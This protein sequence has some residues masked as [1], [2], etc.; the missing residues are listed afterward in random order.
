MNFNLNVALAIFF[1]FIMQSAFAGAP[2]LMT[3]QSKIVLPTGAALES[4]SVNF[5]F[6]ILDSTGTCV[7]YVEDFSAVNMTGSQGV[8]AF[9]L[10]S[11]TKI[12]PPAAVGLYEVFNNSTASYNC[13]AGGTFSP[14]GT[15]N[16][17]VVMQFNDG[18]GWQTL[19][20][21]AINAVPFANYATRAES[22]GA[23][24]STDYL[25]PTTLPTC[26][27]GQ[28]LTWNGTTFTC[29]AGGGGS[30]YTGVTSI[31]NA[32][33]DITLAPAAGTGAV[34][35][36]SGAVSTS[37]T[38]GALTVSGG[39]GVSGGIYTGGAISSGSTVSAVTSM[40]TPQLYGT[41]TPSGNILIDGTSNATKG[42]VLLAGAGGN[43]GIGT[44]S[45]QPYSKLQVNGAATSFPNIIN[46]GA[47]VDLSLSNI[48][49]L[50]SVGGT[51]ITLSNISSGG[52]YTIVIS[53]TTQRTYTFSGCTNS[54][55]SPANGDTIDRT[56]YSIV[57]IV[58]GAATDCFI[59][60]VT[61]Y[62]L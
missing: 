26:A 60:W 41:S 39:I 15:D 2:S 61:G 22:L 3:F 59:T 30:T 43:V 1:S 58:D 18:G 56:T 21:M 23:Y 54:Y 25:R 40:F 7:L 32:S 44:A 17:Q 13:Q 36:N 42:N 19:P 62:A 45:P 57:T 33:G 16:R 46:S 10:G 28:A 37:P 11:G 29:T 49:Y 5:R 34:Q 48:H 35:I 20:Q 4:A 52:S 50:K 38:T 24:P 53:D 6:T 47:S 8:V 14:T 12:Y 31:A 55:Y 27:G 9:P 51:A